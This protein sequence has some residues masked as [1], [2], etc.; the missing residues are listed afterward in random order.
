MGAGTSSGNKQLHQLG[1]RIADRSRRIA[2]QLAR[3]PAILRRAAA[4]AGRFPAICLGQCG[5]GPLGVFYAKLTGQKKTRRPLL[6]GGR[7]NARWGALF[8][9]LVHYPPSNAKND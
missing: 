5:P 4:R 6:A 8:V 7:F 2:G 9:Q 1:A 3:I